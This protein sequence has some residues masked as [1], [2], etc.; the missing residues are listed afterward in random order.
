[1]LVLLAPRVKLRRAVSRLLD[2]FM[3][4][5]LYIENAEVYGKYFEGFVI[6]VSP[7][8]MTA[9][10]AYHCIFS[11]S[12]ITFTSMVNQRLCAA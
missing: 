3:A 6:F 12:I 4:V 8:C 10:H 11:L 1:M 9:V 2:I 7:V 5:R